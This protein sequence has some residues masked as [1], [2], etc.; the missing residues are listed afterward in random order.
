MKGGEVRVRV[1]DPEKVIDP[2][3]WTRKILQSV[4][5]EHLPS[6]GGPVVSFLFPSLS[7]PVA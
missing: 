2:G 4:D 3:A 6:P 7:L 5:P 1:R